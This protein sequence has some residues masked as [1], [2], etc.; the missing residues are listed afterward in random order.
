MFDSGV[1]H[2]GALADSNGV[3]RVGTLKPTAANMCQDPKKDPGSRIYRVQ[4][5]GSCKVL[6]PMY[7]FCHEIPDILDPTLARLKRDPAELE[8]LVAKLP[9]DTQLGS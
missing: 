1:A 2:A 8:S 3:V 6:N 7:S 4:D 5:L 9:L